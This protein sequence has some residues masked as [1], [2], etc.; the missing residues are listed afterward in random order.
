LAEI[1]GMRDDMA[2]RARRMREVPLINEAL[3]YS[4]ALETAVL[5][6]AVVAKEA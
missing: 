4:T 2:R 5:A 6:H 3:E 1:E